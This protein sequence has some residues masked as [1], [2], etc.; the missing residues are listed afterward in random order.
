[1]KKHA[2]WYRIAIIVTFLGL[3]L[4]FSPHAIHHA[5]GFASGDHVTYIYAGIILFVLGAVGLVYF[6]KKC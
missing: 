2:I 6:G 4:A 1:M 3:A 5:V